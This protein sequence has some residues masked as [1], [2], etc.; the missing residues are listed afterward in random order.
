MKLNIDTKA[1]VCI[2]NLRG[3]HKIFHESFEKM[4]EKCLKI[5]S[6]EK[7]FP[8]VVS[9]VYISLYKLAIKG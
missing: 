8:P 5:Y 6:L 3:Y 7:F 4:S 9:L 2:K 1:I